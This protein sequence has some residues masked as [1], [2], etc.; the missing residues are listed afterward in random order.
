MYLKIAE[1][2]RNANKDPSVKFILIT[3]NGKSFS[4]GNDLSNFTNP[5]FLEFDTLVQINIM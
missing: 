2:I 3:G 1:A 5:D 4:S